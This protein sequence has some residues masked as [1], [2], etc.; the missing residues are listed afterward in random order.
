VRP[1]LELRADQ[2]VSRALASAKRKVVYDCGFGGRDPR[3]AGPEDGE[4]K[5]DCSGADSYW[6][7]RD[8]YRGTRFPGG[9]YE[10]SAIVHDA[11][12]EHMDFQKV[13]TARP[14]DVIVYG[15]Y[16]DARG[17]HHEGHCGM[18]IT[19]T[20][21][22]LPKTVAHCCARE[23]LKSAIIVEAF[24]VFWEGAVKS[25]GAIIARPLFLKPAVG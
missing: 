9:W 11:T 4:G 8:R 2:A 18:V 22:G 24:S 3:A 13:S 23:G 12:Q 7:G 1:D 15:D 20:Q 10:T 6:L 16:R 17:K 5:C 21:K 25:R 14:G 19:V